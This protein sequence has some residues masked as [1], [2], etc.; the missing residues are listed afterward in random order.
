MF[1][2]Q[3]SDLKNRQISDP[4]SSFPSD[5]QNYWIRRSGTADQVELLLMKEL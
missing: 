2:N 3:K 1:P 5:S 4:E